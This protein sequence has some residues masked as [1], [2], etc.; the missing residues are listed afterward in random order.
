MDGRIV[1]NTAEH[2]QI[3][4]LN[5]LAFGVPVN[6]EAAKLQGISKR[7]LQR[8]HK[9]YAEKGV[10]GLAHVNRADRLTLRRGGCH[11]DSSR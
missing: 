9:A 4:V 5:H 8:L 10:A 2:R 1:S 6:V 7:Q 11:R 3:V